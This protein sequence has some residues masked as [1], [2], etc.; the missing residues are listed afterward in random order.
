MLIVKFQIA[1][2]IWHA[3]STSAQKYALWE[4]IPYYHISIF[5]KLDKLSN[6]GGIEKNVHFK[7]A[8]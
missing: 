3:A 2:E 6:E 1:S 8:H 5:R 7:R 4:I